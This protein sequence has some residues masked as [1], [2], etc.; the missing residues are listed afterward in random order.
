MCCDNLPPEARAT[1]QAIR[2]GFR[3]PARSPPG[4][5]PSA[6]RSLREWEQGRS[7]QPRPG[8]ECSSAPGPPARPP[9]PVPSAAA[10]GQGPRRG[11]GEGPDKGTMPL[12]EG[13][14]SDLRAGFGSCLRTQKHTLGGNLGWT[15]RCRGWPW[16]H[17]ARW[18]PTP[19][20]HQA[21]RLRDSTR[22]GDVSPLGQDGSR[23][24][25]DHGAGH[26]NRWIS[27]ETARE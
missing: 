16:A 2:E 12:K 17:T 6:A 21:P 25:R 11:L 27:T 20:S 13:C 26:W 18:V 15:H 10:R 3:V 8:L 1:G 19:A 9:P 5:R 4:R 24:V 7:S 14:K 22:E 23:N